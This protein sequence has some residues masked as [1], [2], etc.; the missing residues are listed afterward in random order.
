MREGSFEEPANNRCRLFP[1]LRLDLQLPAPLSCQAIEARPAIILRGTALGGDR[2]FLL[3]PQRH[4]IQRPLIHGQR[5]SANLL[6]APRDSIPV[7]RSQH[8][9]SLED[10]QRQRPL[11]DIRFLSHSTAIL[12]SN[13]KDATL[14]LGKQQ[15]AL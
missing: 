6:D 7:Q 5:I 10:H 8:I 13:R 9:K 11:Q 4:G 15:V 14:P 1:T 2:A 3:K 12:V